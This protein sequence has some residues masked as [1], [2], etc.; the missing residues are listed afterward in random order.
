MYMFLFI[1]RQNNQL[2]WLHVT[3]MESTQS[4]LLNQI[5]I[6]EQSICKLSELLQSK[7]NALRKK[8]H[9]SAAVLEAKKS[10]LWI[11]YLTDRIIRKILT[12]QL[13]KVFNSPVGNFYQYCGP[14]PD[15]IVFDL[16]IAFKQSIMKNLR[17]LKLVLTRFYRID[18]LQ[19][20]LHI[21]QWLLSL[22]CCVHLKLTL[23]NWQEYSTL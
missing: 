15:V 8:T 20:W 6:L 1:F 21:F 2:R 17:L 18:Q 23:V 4:A 19:F 11:F 13:R 7:C 10:S 9:K 3:S 14:V 5:R 12:I 16:L 22:L